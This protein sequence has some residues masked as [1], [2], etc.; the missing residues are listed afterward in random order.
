V[1][2]RHTPRR[3]ATWCLCPSI[4]HGKVA[5]CPM[6]L[7]RP[8][9]TSERPTPRTTSKLHSSA[10]ALR[11]PMRREPSCEWVAIRMSSC[12]WRSR[13]RATN[14]RPEASS[15]ARRALRQDA[16]KG[17]PLEKRH[18]NPRPIQIAESRT[19]RRPRMHGVGVYAGPDRSPDV[20][21][22]DEGERLPEAYVALGP[23]A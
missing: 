2:W 11:L 21:W 20:P 4:A 6:T 7:R 12:P 17:R 1:G 18:G 15:G 19:E 22:G 23:L 16:R 8:V 13:R 9:T 3:G 5:A 10:W 14:L